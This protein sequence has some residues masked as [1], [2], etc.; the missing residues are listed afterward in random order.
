V[1]LQ[2][3][4]AV[5]VPR[6]RLP[7]LAR[8][9]PAVGVVQ[10]D[11][12]LEPAGLDLLGVGEYLAR[13]VVAGG[14][15]VPDSQPGVVHADALEDVERVLLAALG[16]VVLDA[17]VVAALQARHVPTEHAQAAGGL[18]LRGDGED[19]G[20][21]RQEEGDPGGEVALPYF[22]HDLLWLSRSVR[23]A[24]RPGWRS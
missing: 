9:G 7:L 3:L 23:A 2:L 4:D 14:R 12:E 15:V 10:V 17:E 18:R 16:V 20:R 8:V 22:H 13:V 1:L 21:H 6:G 24:P 11:Q 19:E 5:A